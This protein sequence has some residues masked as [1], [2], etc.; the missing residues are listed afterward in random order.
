MTR[1]LVE[2]FSKPDTFYTVIFHSDGSAECACP[3]WQF[4]LRHKVAI[5]NGV[6]YNAECKHIQ[7]ARP[8][9]RTARDYTFGTNYAFTVS[10]EML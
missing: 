1:I 3:H 10:K 8:F 9:L 7:N 5:R 2:S 6:K 4:R